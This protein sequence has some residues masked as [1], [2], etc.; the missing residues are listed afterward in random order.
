MANRELATAFPGRSGPGEQAMTVQRLRAMV[1]HE[2]RRDAGAYFREYR[3]PVATKGDHWVTDA[4][5]HLRR[6]FHLAPD[7]ANK[8]WPVYW[9]AFSQEPG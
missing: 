2:A 1:A 4:W 5:A 7:V 6:D 9:K 8:L 3:G